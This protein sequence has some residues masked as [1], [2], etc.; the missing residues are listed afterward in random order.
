MQPIVMQRIVMQPIVM[1]RI[2]KCSIVLLENS[3]IEEENTLDDMHE[4]MGG[5]NE[6][7]E[8]RG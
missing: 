4:D 1:Q 8:G 2:V 6:G 7:E 3:E 5:E